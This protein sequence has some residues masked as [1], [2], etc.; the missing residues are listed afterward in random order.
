QNV[1]PSFS[2]IGTAKMAEIFVAPDVMERPL[3]DFLENV[4]YTGMDNTNVLNELL[5]VV[6]QL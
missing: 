2:D 4:L 1:L 6:L 5:Q 3:S